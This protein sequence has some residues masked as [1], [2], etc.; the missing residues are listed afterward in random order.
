MINKIA[1]IFSVLTRKMIFFVDGINNHF[2]TTLYYKHLSRRGVT[3]LG[4]PNY[5]SSMAYIDGQG[6]KII[7]IGKD[8]VISRDAM[9][10][11]H[12]YSIET[13]LHSIGKGSNDRH[14]HINNP[15]YIGNNSFI[16]AKAALLPGTT[17][18][19]NCIVGACCVVKGNIPDNSVVVGN[20]CRIIGST[21]D[22]GR[23]LLEK[24][25]E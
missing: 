21:S 5:I 13:A 19:D 23:R 8:V 18:G 25:N 16:G 17:I 12:D 20:P 3:F 9:L 4:R 22:L 10:L 2:F 15:I 7:T 6:Y 24:K 1:K 11:T 14:I